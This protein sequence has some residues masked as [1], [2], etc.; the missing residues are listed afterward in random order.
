M[1]KS[2]RPL[3]ATKTY[4]KGVYLTPAGQARIAD[5]ARQKRIN[6]SAATETLSLLG[7]K[8]DLSEAIVPLV[9]EIVFQALQVYF[10]RFAKLLMRTAVEAG[11]SRT[12]AGELLLQFVRVA[13][14]NNPEQFREALQVGQGDADS[15]AG[16]IRTYFESVNQQLTL[17]AQE[18]LR[19]EIPDLEAINQPPPQ[20][21]IPDE[22]TAEDVPALLQAHIMNAAHNAL[23][24]NLNRFTKLLLQ[25]ADEAAAARQMNEALLLQTIRRQ[26][27]ATPGNEFAQERGVWFGPKRAYSY[28]EVLDWAKGSV[29]ASEQPYGYTLLLS[30]RDGDL[31]EWEYEQALWAGN[32][33][34]EVADWRLVVHEDTANQHAHALV[35]PRGVIPTNLLHEWHT[36][37]REALTRVLIEH[38]EFDQFIEQLG[39]TASGASWR[40]KPDIRPKKV[41]RTA[42]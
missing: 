13:A 1:P 23:E 7:L 30:T 2:S 33:W 39:E 19:Q 16:Q 6:F 32:E 38:Q 26:A 10:N 22:I 5:Y 4:K 11:V 42:A 20:P 14:K 37:M 18:R 28:Q 41:R 36:S 34:V 27:Q 29:H 25:A 12:L 17:I 24:T 9:R 3:R 31:A 21:E 15:L 35:F 8:C 40:W